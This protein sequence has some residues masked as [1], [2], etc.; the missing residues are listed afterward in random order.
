MVKA[1]VDV[2]IL[3]PRLMLDIVREVVNHELAEG[4]DEECDALYNGGKLQHAL[5]ETFPLWGPLCDENPELVLFFKRLLQQSNLAYP[6][7]NKPLEWDSDVMVP[8]YWKV[9]KTREA[10]DED[11]W[12]QS[13]EAEGC[14][15]TLQWQYTLPAEVSETLFDQFVVQSYTVDQ[16]REASASILYIRKAG[17]YQARILHVNGEREHRENV[18][19]IDAAA[20]SNDV[21][22]AQLKSLVSAIEEVVSGYPGLG[23]VQ[24]HVV[25]MDIKGK[26]RKFD[27][28]RILKTCG[29]DCIND[30][31]L[32]AIQARVHGNSRPSSP[33]ASIA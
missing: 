14:D 3:D 1:G 12:L 19:V 28:R 30:R 11:A 31:V 18:V 23:I 17:E 15:H 20:V 8:A 27:L 21:L 25:K 10:A 32:D 4:V 7:G 24:R 22:W 13:I 33:V 16:E 29:S 6:L 2:V 9:N 5:L 26:P